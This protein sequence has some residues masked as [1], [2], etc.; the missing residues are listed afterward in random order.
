[1][2]DFEINEEKMDKEIT[3][4]Q[5]KERA[6]DSAPIQI[7]AKKGLTDRQAEDKIKDR[8][9]EWF[10]DWDIRRK[11]RE[12]MW[13]QIYRKYFTTIEKTKTPSRSSITQPII[14][15]VVEAALPKMVNSLFNNENKF[16]D[17]LTIDPDNLDEK[18]R[19]AAIKRLLEVQLEKADFFE[20]FVDFAKQM[21]LYG[22][23]F[24]KVFWD[25]ERKWVWDRTPKR[26]VETAGGFVIG[27]R[28]KWEERKHYAVTKRQP[29]VEVLD[30][31]DVYP[32]PDIEN[33]QEGRGIFLRS[34]VSRNEL[35][36]MGQG[37]YPVYGNV[38]RL[39]EEANGA[40]SYQESRS[41]RFTPR[42]IHSLSK[43]RKNQV[44]LLEF[45]GEMDLDGDG[46]KEPA[47]ITVA[48]RQVIVRAKANPF[49]HQKRPI[50]RGVMYPVPKELYGIGLVEPV[51][52]QV[53][54]L[55]TLRRQR[56]DNINQSLNAMWQAD[57]TADVE[58]DTLVSAPNQIILSSPLDAV[59]K[60]DQPDV[61]N[62][63]FN[64]AQMVKSDIEQATAPASVQGTP[65]SG[66]LGRTARGA[67]LIIGQALEK[68]GMSTKLVEEMGIRKLLNMFYDLDLQFIDTD[69]VLQSPKLYR[70]I[71]AM[72]LTPEDIRANIKFK[73]VGIS[74]LVSSEAKIN[75]II[76][77]MSVFGKVL[78]PETI[79]Q[80]AKKVW[81]LQG[82]S[83]EEIA[84]MGAQVPPGTE[85][86]VDPNL[87]NAIVGQ[88]TNQG[89]SAAPPSIP[90]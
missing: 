36:E 7:T 19:A 3:K 32:D 13:N 51:L 38:D 48:D 73:L 60:L 31:L 26:E 37:K 17:V 78:A 85:N 71:A 69:D 59:K 64:E 56:I 43:N 49:H 2:S 84:L 44:E 11:P 90:Q 80:L 77:F 76:S 23:S 53:D 45:W 4:T 70:E 88:A 87:S 35:K 46:I 50:V 24:M 82:F 62:N 33:E 12:N 74:E 79:E 22:T 83:T 42:G 34:W 41:D 16:F 55:D 6:E 54:E 30:I 86:T 81:K 10:N 25:V 27:E 39:D 40:E 63:A 18:A 75:Q 15:Q 66:R 65:D 29:G 47:V 20:K 14:F 67:Q 21:M 57:P 9:M 8:L 52:S 72:G 68:F 61:T 28:I 58:L 1:M 5:P 89:T